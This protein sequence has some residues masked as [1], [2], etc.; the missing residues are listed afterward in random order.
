LNSSTQI[1]INGQP[2]YLIP[3]S[4]T[5]NQTLDIYEGPHQNYTYAPY[6]T[7]LDVKQR[8]IASISDNIIKQN[9]G[10]DLN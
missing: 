3:S 4:H 2:N 9:T 6:D 10:F 8:F 5:C 7:H 1:K